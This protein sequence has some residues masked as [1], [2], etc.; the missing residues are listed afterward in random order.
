MTSHHGKTG[1]TLNKVLIQVWTPTTEQNII[2]E[3]SS[4]FDPA[5]N[6][7]FPEKIIKCLEVDLQF[8]GETFLTLDSTPETGQDQD[9][10]ID[11]DIEPG[12]F[13]T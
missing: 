5:A 13:R 12:I 9:I 6:P 7:G 1:I 4:P 2:S 8:E 3:I 10:D 11:I